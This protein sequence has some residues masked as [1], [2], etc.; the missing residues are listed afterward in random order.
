MQK[1]GEGLAH[2]LGL[3]DC[4]YQH[5]PEASTDIIETVFGFP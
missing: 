1:S 3:T 4:Y 2:D 5:S